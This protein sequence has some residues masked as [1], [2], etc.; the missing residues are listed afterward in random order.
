MKTKL[1]NL[2]AFSF[3]LTISSGIGQPVI[4]SQTTNQSVSLGVNVT[5]Q[6]AAMGAAPLSYQWRF[7]SLDLQ[8]ETSRSLSLTNVQLPNAGDYAV[9]VANSSGSITG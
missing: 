7:N 6:V 3:L 1:R 8:G 5:F 4:T 2:A 9:V